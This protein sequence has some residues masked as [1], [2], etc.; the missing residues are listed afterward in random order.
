MEPSRL[1]LG[2]LGLQQSKSKLQPYYTAMLLF[3]IAVFIR[4]VTFFLFTLWSFLRCLFTIWTASASR[5]VPDFPW[6]FLFPRISCRFQLSE[7]PMH[8]SW[9]TQ[10]CTAPKGL[11]I[12]ETH[13]HQSCHSI[14]RRNGRDCMTEP[15]RARFVWNLLFI[16]NWQPS[17]YLRSSFSRLG[18]NLRCQCPGAKLCGTRVVTRGRD[19]LGQVLEIVLQVTGNNAHRAARPVQRDQEGSL[20]FQRHVH[21]RSRPV[22]ETAQAPPQPRQR[23]PP[24]KSTF[25]S[26]SSR[27]WRL[28]PDLTREAPVGLLRILCG[29][30]RS[31]EDD[32]WLSA[33][34][35]SVSR[36]VQSVRTQPVHD[37][38]L[39]VYDLF[40]REG[41]LLPLI[42]PMARDASRS[43]VP[44]VS[45]DHGF[46]S[47]D[48]SRQGGS[49][50]G[51]GGSSGWF[52]GD[53]HGDTDR[54]T[55][56]I[57]SELRTGW[58]ENNNCDASDAK[59]NRTRTACI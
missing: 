33:V 41:V 26:T 55:E 2:W 43:F 47:S 10:L 22:P 59:F 3:F 21:D 31:R 23:P 16:Q 46:A 58:S 42:M 52:W 36:Q 51:S 25:A 38:R 9:T 7:N 54:W 13:R 15:S 6:I 12:K 56:S 50:G 44:T 5:R 8:S 53:G 40:V 4:V 27:S 39:H 24:P 32:E 28:L 20:K 37:S 57:G 48:R 11:A 1:G 49:G 19:L 14:T 45:R 18:I 34:I 29:D 35:I 17:A 30:T